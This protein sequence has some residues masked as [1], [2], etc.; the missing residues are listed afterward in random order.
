MLQPTL[1]NNRWLWECSDFLPQTMQ[2]DQWSPRLGG[3]MAPSRLQDVVL[4]L[5]WKACHW[6]SGK[7]HTWQPIWILCNLVQL[8][9]NQNQ[10]SYQLLAVFHY[11]FPCE[12]L[13]YLSQGLSKTKMPG[14]RNYVACSQNP[15]LFL[16]AL[17]VSY[18]DR[19]LCINVMYGHGITN[20]K[21]SSNNTIHCTIY[22]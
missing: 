11:T 17:D 13:R 12:S 19:L 15:L 1:R 21:S 16:F 14:C 6:P 10:L 22:F 8:V 5:C 4:A 18:L 7:V 9:N 20:S 3:T 2:P